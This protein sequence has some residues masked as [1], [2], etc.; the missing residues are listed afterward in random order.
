M[1]TDHVAKQHHGARKLA[2][3]PMVHKHN[4]LDCDANT[5]C[6]HC[7][8]A[9]KIPAGCD[10]SC[11]WPYYITP[12]NCRYAYDCPCAEPCSA[13]RAQQIL[14]WQQGKEEREGYIKD[15]LYDRFKDGEQ[16]ETTTA[17]IG[18]HRITMQIWH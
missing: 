14:E 15:L 11:G 2:V 7:P 5:F 3:C 1:I 17:Q 10:C 9:D 18:E 12:Q 13:E 4:S 8:D 6:A 16:D